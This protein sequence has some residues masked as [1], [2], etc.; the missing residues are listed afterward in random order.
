MHDER[1]KRK[2][3][4]GGEIDFPTDHQHDFAKGNDRHRG[5]ELRKILKTRAG[6]QEVMVDRLEV[7]GEDECDR[8]DANLAGT[9]ERA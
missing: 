4:P 6:Q 3:H 7:D 1:R 8:K 5:D 9:P 2:D